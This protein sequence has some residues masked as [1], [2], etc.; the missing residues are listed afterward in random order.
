MTQTIVRIV[1]RSHADPGTEPQIKKVFNVWDFARTV[2]SGTPTKAAIN[3]AFAAGPMADLLP[4]LSVSYI[5]DF[6]DIRFLDDPLDPFQTFTSA[7]VGGVAGDSLPSV[8]NVTVQMK[9]GLRGRSFRGSKHF[10]PIAETDTTLDKLIAGAITRWITFMA[11]WLAGFTDGGG[12]VWKPLVVS[13]KLSTFNPTTATVVG[14][15]VTSFQLNTILGIM[16]KRK[17]RN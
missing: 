2:P 11:T 16:R 9:T 10:G 5:A 8:N 4:C 6:V 13:Q 17:E 7:L 15:V 1:T 3:T 12:F 14:N